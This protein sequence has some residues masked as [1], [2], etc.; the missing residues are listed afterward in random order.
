MTILG[1]LQGQIGDQFIQLPTIELIKSLYPKASY[2]AHI[3]RKYAMVAPILLWH[4]DI[5]S[6]RISDAYDNF[7]SDKDRKY[8]ANQNFDLAFHP[9]A[10]HPQNDWWK[11]RHQTEEVAEMFGLPN[12]LDKQIKLK[13]PYNLQEKCSVVIS[14]IGGGG[15]SHKT[16]RPELYQ[17]IVDWLRAKGYEN[18]YQLTY[19]GENAEAPAGVKFTNS[20]Y[21]QS[22]LT[23][24]EAEFYIG[25]DT[26]MTWC[27]SAF[28]KPTLGLYSDSYYGPEFVK[29]IQPVNP[30]A[31][32]LSAPDLNDIPF[33]KIAEQLD[34]LVFRK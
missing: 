33:D 16:I 19:P 23:A 28:Q 6:I 30:N 26:G 4:P 31:K 15:A 12:I 18:I 34:N 20:T 9:M 1:L 8:L 29:N 14:P 11:Y 27:L 5:D 22:V 3:N 24:L 10:P 13:C 25:V 7:P 21:E 2:T 17:K 32:Y